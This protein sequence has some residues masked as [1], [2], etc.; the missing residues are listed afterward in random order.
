MHILGKVLMWMTVLA[1]M[2]AFA[3]TVKA[4][5]VRKGYMIEAEKYKEQNVN[6]ADELKKVQRQVTELEAELARETLGMDDYWPKADRSEQSPLVGQVDPRTGGVVL[7]VG[8]NDGVRPPAGG[9][10]LYYIFQPVPGGG[11]KYAGAFSLVEQG[12]RDD[13]SG[14]RPTWRVRPSEKDLWSQASGQPGW[15]IRSSLPPY[16]VT[17]FSDLYKNLTLADEQLA[18][19]QNN[20]TIQQELFTKADA[21][22]Q[23]RMGELL[24][25]INPPE[26]AEL[27]L[28]FSKGLVTALETEEEKR[29]LAVGELDRLRHELREKRLE[30]DRLIEQS[31]GL[32]QNL[33]AAVTQ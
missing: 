17:R 19:K 33:D 26:G 12:L 8:A 16:A 27:P 7:N 6:Q 13:Q 4:M 32:E 2:V 15:H 10:S 31:K 3:M 23:D 14:Y 11:V 28:E 20:L 9:G 5:N 22:L 25:G 1:A 18:E 30:R 21:Q 29:N 24:G